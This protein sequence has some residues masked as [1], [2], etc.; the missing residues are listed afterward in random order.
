MFTGVPV[1]Y[2]L[3]TD[4]TAETNITVSAMIQKQVKDTT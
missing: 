1:L 4:M 3:F 2:F